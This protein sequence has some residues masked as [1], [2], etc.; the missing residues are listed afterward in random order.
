MK[1]PALAVLSLLLLAQLLVAQSSA[2]DQWESVLKNIAAYQFGQSTTGLVALAKMTGEASQAPP[3][4]VAL[5]KRLLVILQQADATLDGKKEVCRQLSLIGSAESVLSLASLL[6]DADMSDWARYALERNPDP[7]AMAALRGALGKVSGKMK[8]GLINSLGQRRDTAATGELAKLTGDSDEAIAAAAIAALGK[9]GSQEAAQVLTDA[10]ATAG[11]QRRGAVMDALL[12]CADHLTAVNQT[13]DALPIYRSLYQPGEPAH[14]RMAALRGLARTGGNAAVSQVIQA[15]IGDDPAL[16][17]LALRL[18]REMPGQ[19]MTAR[20]T[21]ALGQ[22][23]AALQ[24][25][26]LA[27]LADRGDATARPAIIAATKSN[28]EEVRAAALSALG[29]LG[30]DSDLPLLLETAAQSDRAKASHAAAES[31]RQLRGPGVNLALTK[32]VESSEAK[33]RL[34]AMKALADRN[35]PG[36]AALLVTRL[37]DPDAT[38]RKESLKALA[39]LG[40][41]QELPAVLDLLLKTDALRDAAENA[42][43][44]ICARI[45]EANK[46]AEAVLA[47]FQ[48][49]GA[50]ARCALLRLLGVNE[51]EKALAAL[52]GAVQ[53]ASPEIRDTAIRT[54]ANWRDPRAAE[55]LFNVAKNAADSTH[56]I[57][58]LRGYLRLVAADAKRPV[59]ET[60]RMY[61]KAMSV[62]QRVE[63]KKLILGGLAG[64]ANS[65]ALKM[66]EGCLADEVLK[67]DTAQA[68]ER[69]KAALGKQK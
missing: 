62:A 61:E 11:A 47:G 57:L 66:V 33:I 12:A 35:A 51:G 5:E 53:D 48:G 68:A 46:T 36:G 19:A 69:I 28:A 21:D 4:R 42:A 26:L 44:A 41:E 34:V 29:Q 39:K 32:A 38:V 14:L 60:L 56:Q 22:A 24:A 18:V 52:G 65:A 9:I 7:A 45:E 59:E 27:A 1:R 64:L 63:E 40:G 3:T 50:P 16:R 67:T 25:P 49:A 55:V 54:L 20:F 6:S 2:P 17:R 37:Q 23:P 58:A 31:L 13:K 43:A 30:N 8:T 15:L 10:K